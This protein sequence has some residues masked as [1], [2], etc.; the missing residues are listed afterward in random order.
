MGLAH[1]RKVGGLPP[2]RGRAGLGQVMADARLG[3]HLV[4]YAGQHGQ[5]VA[6]AGGA[7]G[8]HHRTGVPSEH[9]AGFGQG[10]DAGKAVG[11]ALVC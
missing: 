3:Q 10:S 6:A 9:L 5:L 11:E 1:Q 8:R 7:P 4:R 2:A